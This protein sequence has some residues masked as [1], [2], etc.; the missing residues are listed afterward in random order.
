MKF[1]RKNMD[2]EPLTEFK[3]FK[4]IKKHKLLNGQTK[5]VR[6]RSLIYSIESDKKIIIKNNKF[7][8]EKYKI[9]LYIGSINSNPDNFNYDFAHKSHNDGFFSVFT[10][11]FF[12]SQKGH[13]IQLIN[14]FFMVDL[15]NIE[16]TKCKD[17]KCNSKNKKW[18]LNCLGKI[19]AEDFV[20][21]LKN[22]IYYYEIPQEC[23][24]SIKKIQ[25]ERR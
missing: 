16:Y 18:C 9:I 19:R 2:I 11:K 6:E 1:F 14:N 7:I 15:Y 12:F 20:A 10:K 3:N 25:K 23:I 4:K 13:S 24:I 21:L 5:N 8:S 17:K 22:N